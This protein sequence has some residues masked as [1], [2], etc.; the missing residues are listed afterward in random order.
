ME[1][2]N[3]FLLNQIS[4]LD[5]LKEAD[6]KSFLTGETAINFITTG[7]ENV[8]DKYNDAHTDY[9]SY[10]MIDNGNYLQYSITYYE[11]KKKYETSTEKVRFTSKIRFKTPVPK[12][13]LIKDDIKYYY[14]GQDLDGIKYYLKEIPELTNISDDEFAKK[15]HEKLSNDTLESLDQIYSLDPRTKELTWKG[16][17]FRNNRNIFYNSPLSDNEYG[18]LNELL[19]NYAVIYDAIII[20]SRGSISDTFSADYMKNQTITNTLPIMIRKMNHEIHE[21]FEK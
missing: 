15:Y 14:V 17:Y 19:N 4:L 10:G 12:E 20:T 11:R 5:F 8:M 16:H 18:R 13:E 6:G 3:K 1:L 9:I 7:L 2:L 21:I